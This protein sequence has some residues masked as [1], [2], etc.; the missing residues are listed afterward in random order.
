[1][2]TLLVYITNQPLGLQG[3]SRCAR[4]QATVKIPHVYHE[5]KTA[6]IAFSYPH[7]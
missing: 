5:I 6:L 7:G 2:L 3:G 4:T 1:M